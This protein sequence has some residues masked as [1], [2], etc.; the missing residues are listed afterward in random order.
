MNGM[1]TKVGRGAKVEPGCA[2]V[3]PTKPEPRGGGI[4]QWLSIGTSLTSMAAMIATL[5]NVFK[6]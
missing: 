4:Q 3:V 1:V 6:K 5:V 2:I